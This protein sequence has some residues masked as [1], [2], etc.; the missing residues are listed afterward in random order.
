VG[1]ANFKF[2]ISLG[3]VW[4]ED[5][6][7]LGVK[8]W[9]PTAEKYKNSLNYLKLFKRCLKDWDVEEYD[10]C[11]TICQYRPLAQFIIEDEE[12]IPSMVEYL[13]ER[14]EEH[15]SE[16]QSLTNLV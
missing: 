8:I 5:E 2:N 14:S 9:L 3:F 12:Q 4:E 13:K 16:L 7:Y 11:Y 1:G 10:N 6:I 15:T